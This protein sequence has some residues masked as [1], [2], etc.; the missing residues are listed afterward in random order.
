MRSWGQAEAIAAIIGTI[1]GA[2]VFTLPYMAVQAGLGISTIWLIVV[3]LLVLYFHLAFGEVVLRTKNDFRL[4]GYVGHYLGKEAKRFMLLTTFLTF[5]F[6]LLLYLLLGAQF[7]KV[8]TGSIWSDF[9]LPIGL[10][11]LFLWFF[12]SLV[13]LS[14]NKGV[15][16]VNFYLSLTLV[17]L[18]CVIIGFALPHFQRGNINFFQ[19]SGRWGWLI[20][21]GVIFYALNG[22]IAIPEAAKV[23]RDHGDNKGKSL[24]RVILVG[25]LVPAILYFL[26]MIAVV[27][28]SG[29]A[30]TLTAIQGLKGILGPFI[31]FLGAG[32]GFLAVVTS[33][34]I[35]ANYIKNSFKYDFQWSPFVSYFW[36]LA[37]P[38]LLYFLHLNNILKLISFLGGALG[39]LEGIMLILVFQKAKKHSDLQPTYS[40]P[41]RKNWYPWLIV[42]L[43]IG[44]LCQTFLAY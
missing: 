26:F 4:P 24:K 22:M 14:K 9:N 38:L 19:F 20:P 29:R 40:L 37:G 11:V 43:L 6:S 27:G 10:A 3:G 25:T 18:F 7:L 12:L 16:R 8:I 2:G 23:L 41:L 15:A 21:Y 33:Y 17:F 44:A 1:V 31:V 36:V 13:I 35:F 39:G 28:A 5:G 32:L 30:T 42:A 34:L